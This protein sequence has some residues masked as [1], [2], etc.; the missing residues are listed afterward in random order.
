[1]P[2]AGAHAL[3]WLY[4]TDPRRGRRKTRARG[5][6]D[7]GSELDDPRVAAPNASDSVQPGTQSAVIHANGFCEAILPH[8]SGLDGCAEAP[9]D[10]RVALQ[11]KNHCSRVYS[12][13]RWR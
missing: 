12:F 6:A 4:A 10:R 7:K 3:A 5:Y 8:V 9:R 2:M 1:M 11:Q 13:F